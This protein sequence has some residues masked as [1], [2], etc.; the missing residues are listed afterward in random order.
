MNK[1][2]NIILI[3]FLI[4][5]GSSVMA[6]KIDTI[7]VIEHHTLSKGIFHSV[8]GRLISKKKHDKIERLYSIYEG[9]TE[10]KYVM[11]YDTR[12][13]LKYSCLSS[14]AETNNGKAIF[15]FKNGKIKST[16]YYKDSV[17]VG[18]WQLFNKK[19]D[20]IETIEL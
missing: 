20:L 8:N 11:Y 17:E 6:Q 4:C 13:N 5:L 16:G 19:G 3:T 1:T 12:N 2:I 18:T 9:L 14:G 10:A 15:Y 7:M